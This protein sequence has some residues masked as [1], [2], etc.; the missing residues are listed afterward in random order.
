MKTVPQMIEAYLDGVTALRAAVAGMFR[1]HLEARPVPG[2]WSTIEVVA[3]LAD[4]ES[5][6]ADRMKRV[7]ALDRPLLLSA[8]EDL[9]ASRLGYQSRDLA[10][11]LTIIEST[12]LQMSRILRA[13][14]NES[15]NRVGIHS[16]K[17]VV[18]LENLVTGAI[19]HVTHHLTFVQ[20]KRKAL[21][22]PR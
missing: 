4:F 12:R 7:I 18:T 6:L 5:I 21:G 2:K 19:N 16:Y 14:P 11:E 10:E 13:L 9:F 22:L 15:L 20:E 1:E 3:H 17:G 8:D